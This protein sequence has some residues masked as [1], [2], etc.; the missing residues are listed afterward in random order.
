MM[1]SPG[2]DPIE[3]PATPLTEREA[4]AALSLLEG[5]GQVLLAVS[6]GPDSMALMGLAAGWARRGRGAPPGV[7]VIDHGLRPG[8]DAEAEAVVRRAGQMG[9]ACTVLAWGGP[10]PRSAV[11]RAARE[12]R[13]RLLQRHAA[14]IGAGVIA[15]GHTLDD[16]AET[17]MMRLAHGSG[18]AGLVGMRP[19]SQLGGLPLAR[20]FLDIPKA[21]LV[22]TCA[23]N[24]WPW[25]GDP[26]NRDERFE[27]TRWRRIMP[28]LAA[29]GLDA[30][31]VGLFARRM[32]ELQDALDATARRALEAAACNGGEIALAGFAR[33]PFA[34]TSRAL[35]LWI[36]P[37]GQGSGDPEGR[38]KPM[39]LKR[40]ETA[41]RRL[42]AAVEAGEPLV[43]TLAGQVLALDGRG[44]LTRR[45]ERRRR[46]V[47]LAE[48]SL[49]GKAGGGD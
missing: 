14:E 42:L 22:A 48:A 13:Y 18:P 25:T 34:V 39:R 11:Q 6:G 43:L 5:R 26:S 35:A 4:D 49:L 24:G 27:R 7:A 3:P 36:E 20:P 28:L 17:L 23:A 37:S 15:T 12:A 16:Q 33:E 38:W 8:S 9:L 45:P 41:T 19:V 47:N 10:K 21:R 44:R 40:L 29:E 31:R 32:A 30:G 46:G 1:L 2:P